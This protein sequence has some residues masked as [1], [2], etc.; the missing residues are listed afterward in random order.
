MQEEQN[1]NAFQELNI[2]ENTEINKVCD[3]LFTKVKQLTNEDLS[4]CGSMAK[5][6]DGTL[7]EDYQPKDLDLVISQWGFRLLTSNLEELEGVL[8]IEKLPGRIILYLKA[9][10]CI[11]IWME[12]SK[13]NFTPK[14]YKN[15]LK[16]T[17]Y[18]D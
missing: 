10:L 2:F 7:P 6:F 11:E 3:A 15:K 16:Y 5:V 13:F 8:M 1:Y 4:I 18:G 17:S 9:Y 14:F 12:S